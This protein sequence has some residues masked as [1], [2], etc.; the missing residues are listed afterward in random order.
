MQFSFNSSITEPPTGNQVR[1]NNANQA[2]A[3][4]IWFMKTT[5]DSID[6]SVFFHL[7]GLSGNEIYL[8]D[9]DDFSK[10]QKYKL[11]AD[12]IDKTT[13]FELP[14][15]WESGGTPLPTQTV[16]AVLMGQVAS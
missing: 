11:T 2:Q 6:V 9:R 5:T 3:T 7:L 4:K 1:M 12:V 10:R 14:V 13:Y 15:V 16:V 8:Q